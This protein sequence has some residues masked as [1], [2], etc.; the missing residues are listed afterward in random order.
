M[1]ARS[2]AQR[3]ALRLTLGF[4]IALA[5]LAALATLLWLCVP[6]D[7]LA[8]RLASELSARAGRAIRIA[9]AEPALAG[10]AP[11]L[12]AFDLEIELPGGPLRFARFELRPLFRLSWFSGIASLRALAEGD[13]GHADLALRLGQQLGL[14]GVLADL[15]LRASALIAPEFDLRGRGTA[16]FEL[17]NLAGLP[18]GQLELDATQGSLSVPGLEVAIPFDRL[19]LSAELGSESGLLRLLQCELAGPALS[20]EVEGGIGPGSA[21]DSAPLELRIALRVE[22]ALR[23]ALQA[24]GLP[25]DAQGRA[26]LRIGGS[27]ARPELR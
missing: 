3:G 14:R 17:E 20:A 2:N 6:G 4:A 5:A 22:P 10:G 8:R 13:S 7:E 16:H 11:A 26:R 18:R 27:A 19:A 23:P 1:L 15:D 21:F 9:R 12:R 25:L 24:S